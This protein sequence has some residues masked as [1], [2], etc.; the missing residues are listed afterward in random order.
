M[1]DKQVAIRL[2]QSDLE[3]LQA[4][5]KKIRVLSR[6]AIAREALRIGLSELEREPARIL[7]DGTKSKRGRRA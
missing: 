5:T 1:L 7:R 4:L 2:D 6:N 3:R